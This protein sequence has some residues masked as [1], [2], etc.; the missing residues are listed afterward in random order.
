MK[1]IEN[2]QDIQHLVDSFYLQ[3]MSDKR[4]GHFFTEVVHLDMKKHMPVMYDFWETT[5]F[6]KMKYKG[7]PMLK[8]IHMDE[9][10]PMEAQHFDQWLALWTATIQN[11]FR[12][13]R[14]DRAI[15][16]ANQIAALMQYKIK[17]HR[18]W[19]RDS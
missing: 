6:G 19:F 18:D 17:Q 3:A 15:K 10:S 9:I 1:D 12:G 4:I 11:N 5:L 14:A 8:H 16:K 2:R 7:N 13:P